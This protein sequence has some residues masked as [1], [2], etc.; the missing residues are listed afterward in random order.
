MPTRFKPFAPVGTA[1]PLMTFVSFIA[2]LVAC[3]ALG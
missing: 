3:M 1:A 2:T